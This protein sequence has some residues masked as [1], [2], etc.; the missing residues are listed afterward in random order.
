VTTDHKGDEVWAEAAHVSSIID[1]AYVT[2]ARKPELGDIVSILS[3]VLI[4]YKNN[5]EAERDVAS[6]QH[7][8]DLAREMTTQLPAWPSRGIGREM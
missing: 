8:H 4:A 5:R 2:L 7:A 6:M 3:D 1:G